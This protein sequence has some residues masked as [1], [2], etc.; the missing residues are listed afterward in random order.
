MIKDKI[1]AKIISKTFPI[2]ILTLL[3]NNYFQFTDR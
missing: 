1:T 3:I 2:I